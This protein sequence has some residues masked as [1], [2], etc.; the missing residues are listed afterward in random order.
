MVQ[1]KVYVLWN[2]T[3]WKNHQNLLCFTI[4]SRPQPPQKGRFFWSFSSPFQCIT[5]LYSMYIL[6]VLEFTLLLRQVFALAVPD[7]S[8]FKPQPSSSVATWNF[9]HISMVLYSSVEKHAIM[10]YLTASSYYIYIQSWAT[11]PLRVTLEES[12]L[13]PQLAQNLSTT[14]SWTL[15]Q[16]HSLSSKLVTCCFTPSQ[17]VWLYLERERER[18]TRNKTNKQTKTGGKLPSGH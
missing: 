6:K 5:Q 9:E 7:V 12:I 8:I 11:I 18:R 13:P 16:S 10:L 3:D 2:S 14:L 1:L 4:Y 15:Q 17:P